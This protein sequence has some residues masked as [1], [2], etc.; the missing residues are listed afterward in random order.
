MPFPSVHRGAGRGA[1]SARPRSVVHRHRQHGRLGAALSGHQAEAERQLRIALRTDSTFAVGHLYL[2]RVLQFNGQLDSA[3]SHFA[4]MGPLRAW[5]PTI[6]GEGYV[7]AQQGPVD[8]ARQVLRQL[9]SLSRTEYVTAYAVA[10]VHA[11]L[12]ERDSAFVWLNKAVDERT[13]WLLWLNRDRRWDP[14][15]SDPRFAAI[16]TRVGVPD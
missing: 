5:V 7:Y 2:G 13:H 15:R 1:T 9:D 6:A 3:L 4:A 8:R 14:I 10:L 16:A 12:G 11:A